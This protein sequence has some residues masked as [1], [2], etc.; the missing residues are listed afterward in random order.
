MTWM[1]PLIMY[2]RD[3]ILPKDPAQAKRLIKEATR[4]I[5]IGGELYRR[6][7]SFPLLR[8]IEGKETV[9]D[10]RKR[11]MRPQSSY[12]PSPP[13]GRSTNGGGHPKI[14]STNPR[15]SEVPD[16]GDRLLYQVGR[17]RARCH[18]IGREDQALI[19]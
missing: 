3:E 16:R 6:G 11:V 8:C 10:S 13:P 17:S 12:I 4:Y 9:K 19:L 5:I 14:L 15:A 18:N 1:S 7:F 2:L